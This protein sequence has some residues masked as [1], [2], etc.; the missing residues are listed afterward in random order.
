MIDCTAFLTRAAE[1]PSPY[2]NRKAAAK[3]KELKQ[4]QA[5]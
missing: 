4:E 3:L 1:D 2:I 5:R